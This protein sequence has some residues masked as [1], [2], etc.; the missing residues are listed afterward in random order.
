M[1]WH[2]TNLWSIQDVHFMK[3][4]L[5]DLW[6]KIN[7]NGTLVGGRLSFY[8]H[9]GARKTPHLPRQPRRQYR[10]MFTKEHLTN[11]F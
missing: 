5:V 6:F 10:L 8:E 9:R 3:Y 2:I 1:E 4:V 7:L 11:Q